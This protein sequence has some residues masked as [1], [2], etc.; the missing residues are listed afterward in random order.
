MIIEEKEYLERTP[1]D[2]SGWQIESLTKSYRQFYVNA[3]FTGMSA[4]GHGK[5]HYNEMR[6]K[7]WK[8]KIVEFGG[9][10]PTKKEVSDWGRFNGDGSV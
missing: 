5:A 8:E 1:K 3:V 9:K 4:G 2:M 10:V 6:A 7:Q